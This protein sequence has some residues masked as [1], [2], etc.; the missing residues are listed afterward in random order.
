MT[1]KLYYEKNKNAHLD[2][3]DKLFDE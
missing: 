3:F 1:D 2:H